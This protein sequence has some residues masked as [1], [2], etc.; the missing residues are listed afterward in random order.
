M[1]SGSRPHLVAVDPPL[2]CPGGLVSVR[3][4]RLVHEGGDPP[5]VTLGDEPVRIASAS[6]T[7]VA[8]R[9]PSDVQGGTLPVRLSTVPRDGVALT[10]ARTL[11][12]GIHQVDSPV[13][14]Q[15]GHL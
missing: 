7:R 6:N 1:P 2:A 4:L 10:I 15:H 9:V 13:F 14:D 12:T 3:G 5:V 8:F 11:A